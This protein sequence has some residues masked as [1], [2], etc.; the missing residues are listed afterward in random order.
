MSTV[1]STTPKRSVVRFDDLVPRYSNAA[2]A[3]AC[4]AVGWQVIPWR[5]DGG[6]KRGALIDWPGRATVDLAVIE[7]WFSA[8]GPLR[9]DEWFPGVVCGPRSGLWV[10]DIDVKKARGFDTLA[11]LC[12]Q[13]GASFADLK[14]FTVKT[15]SGGAHLLWRWPD[16]GRKI[17]NSAG[18]IGPGLDTRGRHG[19]I[20]AP[21]CIVPAGVYRVVDDTAPVHAPGWLLELVTKP[22]R[23]PVSQPLPAEWVDVRVSIRAAGQR[24]SQA[25]PGTRNP[26]LNDEAFALGKLARHQRVSEAEAWRVLRE[27]CIHCG[28]LADDGEEQ[29]RKT[30]ESGWRA[31]L[32]AE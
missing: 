5:Y 31:G 32:D 4:A 10:L 14:T 23:E 17:G 3:A 16:D 8:A 24:L 28:L 7:E 25:A 1:D 6:R 9:R 20:A 15:P 27:A 13:H 11:K 2:V 22:A 30:F 29:C 21:G 26:T 19:F 18:R 12:E